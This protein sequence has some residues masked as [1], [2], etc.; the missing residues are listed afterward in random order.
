[1]RA[2]SGWVE[3]D[4]VAKDSGGELPENTRP[5]SRGNDLRAE[6]TGGGHGTEPG[7]HVPRSHHHRLRVEDDGRDR[8]C[9]PN[10][11]ADEVAGRLGGIPR[12]AFC[13]WIVWNFRGGKSTGR[14][15]SG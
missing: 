10:P 14:F 9:A 13:T 1:M 11:T 3:C 7:S 2:P 12:R 6:T 15:R 5:A 4:C 8:K